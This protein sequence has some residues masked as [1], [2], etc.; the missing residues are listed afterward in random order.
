MASARKTDPETSHAAAASV[1]DVNLTKQYILKAL[2][3]PRID[4]DL[5]DAYRQQKKA[6]L[7]SESGI[8]SRRSELVRAGLVQDSGKRLLTRSGRSSI[9]WERV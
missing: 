3:R 6:P 4:E 9:V 5:I 8:R 1:G 7:Q 2:R